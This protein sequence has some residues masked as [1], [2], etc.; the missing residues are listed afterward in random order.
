MNN[1]IVQ[2]VDSFLRKRG[3][4]SPTIGKL[5]EI[6][7]A[8]PN[9]FYAIDN[10]GVFVEYNKISIASRLWQMIPPHLQTKRERLAWMDAAMYRI[11]TEQVVEFAGMTACYRVGFHCIEPSKFRMLVTR[12]NS[13]VLPE[14][15]EWPL[16]HSF[17]TQLFGPPES[18]QYRTV[19]GCLKVFYEDMVTVLHLDENA[20]WRSGQS[21]VLV[22][23]PGVGKTLFGS[24]LQHLFGTGVGRPFAYMTSRTQFNDEL[25]ENALLWIDDE[26]TRNPKERA[27]L[28]ATMKQFVAA[29]G[30]RRHA[31]YCKPLEVQARGRLLWCVNKDADALCAIPRMET[32]VSDK[33]M[34]FL[35]SKA[36]L[37]MDLGE[38]EGR[39]EFWNQ[40][41]KELPA[42]AHYL[43]EEFQI[44]EDLHCG[45]FG[46]KTFHHPEVVALLTKLEY[47]NHLL[48]IID[49]CFES[50][51]LSEH[52]FCERSDGTMAKAWVGRSL[53]LKAVIERDLPI[54]EAQ[55][56]FPHPTS[57]GRLLGKLAELHPDRVAHHDKKNNGNGVWRIWPSEKEHDAKPEPKPNPKRKPVNYW[58]SRPGAA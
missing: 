2:T 12:T 44:S 10:S 53:T 15:G 18:L 55:V 3:V 27:E 50:G 19:C 13:P 7:Y 8:G 38:P 58:T 11:E 32:G 25:F 42:F 49:H 57:C 24:F 20:P 56:L 21:I 47:E 16:I 41:D 43:L 36:T 26:S 9:R 4:T 46:V 23:E 14:Q 1:D 40:I 5:S 54:R 52:Q 45:R 22:G 48:D 37:P 51:E 31:K 30:I 33:M 29:S 17:T 35:A 28:A 6:F 39:A 34:L